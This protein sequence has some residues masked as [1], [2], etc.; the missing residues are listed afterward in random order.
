MLSSIYQV[1]EGV[2]DTI[3]KLHVVHCARMKF[4]IMNFFTK[5]DQIRRKL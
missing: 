5:C 4:S 2:K 1:H 3:Y